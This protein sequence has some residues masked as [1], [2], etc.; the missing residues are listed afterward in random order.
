MPT[1]FLLIVTSK[2]L[3]NSVLK[4]GHKILNLLKVHDDIEVSE[5]F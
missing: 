1:Y 5:E 2:S 4:G 3:E